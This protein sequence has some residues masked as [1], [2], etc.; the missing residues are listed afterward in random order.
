MVPVVKIKQEEK[1]PYFL[2]GC[3]KITSG[4]KRIH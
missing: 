4:L 2:S 1:G 3:L